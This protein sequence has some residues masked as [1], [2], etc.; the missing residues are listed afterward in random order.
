MGGRWFL[1]P[2]GWR[3]GACSDSPPLGCGAFFQAPNL[4]TSNMAIG[5][6][7]WPWRQNLCHKFDPPVITPASWWLITYPPNQSY[8]SGL[9]HWFTRSSGISHDSPI[10][11]LLYHDYLHD[12]PMPLS[13]L[14]HDYPTIIYYNPMIT[15]WLSHDYIKVYSCDHPVNILRS[16]GCSRPPTPAARAEAARPPRS[17]GSRRGPGSVGAWSPPG[18]TRGDFEPK[19]QN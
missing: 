19:M 10:L 9:W 4:R 1:F 8:L 12:Y 6:A 3:P 5:D 7:L 15:P 14:S 17:P 2:Y 11:I 18:E 16:I 13:K